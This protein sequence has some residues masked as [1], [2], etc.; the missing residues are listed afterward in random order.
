MKENIPMIVIIIIS[1][2]LIVNIIIQE[3]EKI[4]LVDSNKLIVSYHDKAYKLEEVK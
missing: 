3:K 2:F 1:L 4:K